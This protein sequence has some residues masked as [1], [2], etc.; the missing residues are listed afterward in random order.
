MN[1]RRCLIAGC[2][3]ALLVW[4]AATSSIP[5]RLA[6]ASASQQYQLVASQVGSPPV[7]LQSDSYALNEGVALQ[8]EVAPVMKSENYQVEGIITSRQVYLPLV[9]L[10]R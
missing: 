3:L 8:A 6:G 5:P 2:T 7:A 1:A 9:S 10:Q 4:L